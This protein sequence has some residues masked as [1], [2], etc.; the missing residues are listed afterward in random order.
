[1]NSTSTVRGWWD[2]YCCAD[3]KMIRAPFPGPS[4]AVNLL[5]A[6]PAEEA[7]AAFADIMAEFDYLFRENAGGTYNCRLIAGTDSYSL[8]SYGIALD[9]NPSKNPSGGT[10]NDYPPGFSDAVEGLTAGGKQVFRWGIVFDTPDPM[11]WEV[12]LSPEQLAK[13]IDNMKRGP[14][15]EPN[16]DQVS[17]W[18]QNSWTKAYKAGLLTDDSMPQDVLE[19]E[20]LMVYLARAE[21]I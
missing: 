12:N 5:I 8:H 19:V 15:G 14:N 11:H 2:D 20:Q 7:W 9:L 17:D 10:K 18:A 4:G 16:W 13:G 21:V 1:V 3:E 6:P